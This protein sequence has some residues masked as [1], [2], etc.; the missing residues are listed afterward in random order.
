ML[1]N[2]PMRSLELVAP[3]ALKKLNP[4][5]FLARIPGK[6]YCYRQLVVL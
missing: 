5:L 6:R 2:S 4:D 1:A 3:Q